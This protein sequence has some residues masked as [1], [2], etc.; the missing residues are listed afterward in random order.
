MLIAGQPMNPNL[1]E[2]V[3]MVENDERYVPDFVLYTGGSIVSKRLKHF[4]R[5]A[6]ETWVINETGE[7]TDTFMNLTQVIVGEGTVVADQVR[8]MLEQ[9]PHPFVQLWDELLAKVRSKAEAYEP[10]Y[11][12]M[13]AV[14][15]FESQCSM[16]NG[17]RSMV[18]GQWSIL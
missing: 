4:L 8:F 5:K 16:V 15:Y 17:Q 11:S 6:K 7:V 14:K 9:Q 10:V 1:D 13:S 3:C 2:A 12:Q 18:N